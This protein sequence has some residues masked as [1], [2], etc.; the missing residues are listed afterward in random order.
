VFALVLGDGPP[1]PRLGAVS[2]LAAWC[3]GVLFVVKPGAAEASAAR[4]AVEELRRSGANI[5]GVVLNQVSV[6]REEDEADA[7]AL[8]SESHAN[9]V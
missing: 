5:L 6:S 7:E 8:W 1:S 3:D 4:S 2:A 9:P